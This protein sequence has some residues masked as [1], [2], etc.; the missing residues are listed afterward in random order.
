MKRGLVS[1]APWVFNQQNLPDKMGISEDDKISLKFIQRMESGYRYAF[2]SLINS[3][4]DHDLD[5]LNNCLEPSLYSYVSESLSNLKSKQVE[6]RR[7]SKKPLSLT[8][9]SLSFHLGVGTNRK[10]NPKKP[11]TLFKNPLEDQIGQSM[12]D[13]MVPKEHHN[14]IKNIRIYS[15][16]PLKLVRSV[17]SVDIAFFGEP[18]LGLFE[19]SEQLN[20]VSK[21]KEYH[22]LKFEAEINIENINKITNNRDF[23]IELIDNAKWSLSDIDNKLNGNS[24]YSNS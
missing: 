2:E 19:G 24:F 18:I 22:F 13:S 20:E 21:G 15:F 12:L 16:N 4:C 6:F 14:F 9:L 10:S 7:L 5:A 23:A 1:T 11:S 3:Y 8:P 17:I